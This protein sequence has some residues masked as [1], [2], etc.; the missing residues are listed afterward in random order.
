MTNVSRDIIRCVAWYRRA[1]Y[2]HL[3]YGPIFDSSLE[4]ISLP[5]GIY[6]FDYGVEQRV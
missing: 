1:A 6:T 2:I 5:F 4:C 3:R